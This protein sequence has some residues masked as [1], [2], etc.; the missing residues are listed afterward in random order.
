MR[1]PEYHI[2]I[3][4]GGIM[5]AYHQHIVGN[6][7]DKVQIY[8]PE[9]SLINLQPLDFQVNISEDVDFVTTEFWYNNDVSNTI[10]TW[11]ILQLNSEQEIKPIILPN[12][13]LSE[14][15]LE[16]KIENSN[17]VRFSA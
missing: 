11:T 8:D 12:D 7:P 1:E 10:S 9:L 2:D 16:T 6:I 3:I 14:E 17:R 13:F 4:G 5:T 15:E